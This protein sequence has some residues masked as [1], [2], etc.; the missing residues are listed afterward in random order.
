M[1]EIHISNNYHDIINDFFSSKLVT[2]PLKKY[3]DL[4]SEHFLEYIKDSRLQML[5][6]SSI[7]RILAQ[8]YSKEPNFDE[9]LII[10]FFIDCMIQYGE[11]ISHLPL[12]KFE[13]KAYLF[14]KLNEKMSQINFNAIDQKLI[15]QGLYQRTQKIEANFLN[16]IE[17]ME[18]KHRNMM[19]EQRLYYEG[20]IDQLNKKITNLSN[21]QSQNGSVELF[22][23][24]K[25]ES[26]AMIISAINESIHN[27]SIEKVHSLLSFLTKNSK[28]FST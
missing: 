4:L 27:D 13:D 6:I 5:P 7:Y 26:Q 28:Q 15:F 3:E 1:T 25:G 24:L 8:F 9:K 2:S 11:Q 21:F 16:K 23:K 22:N 17:E 12:F 19:D 20:R 14:D 10:D 18:Q